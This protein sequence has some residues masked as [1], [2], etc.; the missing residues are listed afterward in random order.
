[1]INTYIEIYYIFPF[2]PD[3]CINMKRIVGNKQ[4]NQ[5]RVVVYIPCEHIN[6]YIYG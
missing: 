1:M 5:N 4:K 6:T 3:E 2:R